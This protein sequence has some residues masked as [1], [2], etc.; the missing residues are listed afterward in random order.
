MSKQRERETFIALMSRE[1]P[2]L[3]NAEHIARLILRHAATLARIGVMECNGPECS[4]TIAPAAYERLWN[5]HDAYCTQT[6]ER[7]ENRIRAI[8]KPLGMEVKF[9]GDPRGFPVQ[10]FLPSGKYN[11]W[12]GAESG[13]GVG[14]E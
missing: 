13:Y 4:P 9:G 10:L 12:G 3:P 6:A 5:R 11:T 14:N 1:F 7:A 2:A 8:C